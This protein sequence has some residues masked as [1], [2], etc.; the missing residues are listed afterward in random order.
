ME[1][2]FESEGVKYKAELRAEKA[3]GWGRP[4]PKSKAS[5]WLHDNVLADLEDRMSGAAYDRITI[6]KKRMMLHR[7]AEA[8]KIDNK[9]ITGAVHSRTAGC[10]CGCSPGFRLH[11]MPSGFTLY[12]S[13]I[14]PLVVEEYDLPCT[15]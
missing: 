10:G 14:K 4:A 2:I 7:A 3:K 5:I 6:A 11:N 12:V 9:E 8:L 1:A 15:D 13:P